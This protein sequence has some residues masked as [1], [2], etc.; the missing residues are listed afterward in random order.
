MELLLSVNDS[1]LS[2]AV[3]SEETCA[4]INRYLLYGKSTGKCE[5]K[6]KISFSSSI[7]A[8]KIFTQVRHAYVVHHL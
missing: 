4:F 3:Y 8:L 7:N 2:V 6:L 1:G 5:C